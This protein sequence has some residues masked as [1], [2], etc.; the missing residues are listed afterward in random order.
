MTVLAQLAITGAQGVPF[1]TLRG[2]GLLV[3]GIA[4]AVYRIISR[5]KGKSTDD[6]TAE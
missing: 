2:G 1:I 6:N 5:R 4:I 3:A